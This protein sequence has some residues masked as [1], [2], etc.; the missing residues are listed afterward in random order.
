[1]RLP[2]VIAMV[3]A[4]AGCKSPSSGGGDGGGGGGGGM[5]SG[6]IM[7]IATCQDAVVGLRISCDGTQS[8]DR[9]AAR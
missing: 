5:T 3:V 8:A 9:W 1:M 2:C 4:L 7:A 6:A